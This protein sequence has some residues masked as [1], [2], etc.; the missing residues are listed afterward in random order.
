LNRKMQKFCV[1]FFILLSLSAFSQENLPEPTLPPLTAQT[2]SQSTPQAT[3]TTQATPQATQTTQ[4]AQPTFKTAN[5]IE[6]PLEL[7]G[8]DIAGVFKLFGPPQAVYAVRGLKEWQ[9]DVVFEYKDLDFYIFRNHVWQASVKKANGIAVGDPKKTI[10]IVHSGK[11]KDNG[12][13]FTVEI[14]NL[15][16]KTAIRYEIDSKGKI[17]AIFIYRTDY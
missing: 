13:N 11:A 8:L 10:E 9:D 5:D 16:W 1:L 12:S 17:S 14:P 3:Q 15:P 4:P 7:I 2:A 6:D